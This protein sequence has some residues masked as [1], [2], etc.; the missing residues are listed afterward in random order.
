MAYCIYLTTAMCSSH[1]SFNRFLQR[2]IAGAELHGI[3]FST[4]EKYLKEIKGIDNSRATQ[5]V[6]KKA[7]VIVNETQFTYEKKV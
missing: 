6:Q 5:F 4:S 1:L 2:G 7:G 3:N